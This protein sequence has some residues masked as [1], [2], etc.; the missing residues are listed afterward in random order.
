MRLEPGPAEKYFGITAAPMAALADWH[1]RITNPSLSLRGDIKNACNYLKSLIDNFDFDKAGIAPYKTPDWAQ[2]LLNTGNSAA[3]IKLLEQVHPAKGKPSSKITFTQIRSVYESLEI[4]SEIIAFCENYIAAVVTRT[5][6]TDEPYAGYTDECE[7]LKAISFTKNDSVKY[8][9]V[10]AWGKF[11]PIREVT[12]LRTRAES[13]TKDCRNPN[14]L[15]CR[16]LSTVALFANRFEGAVDA[17]SY[18]DRAALLEMLPFLAEALKKEGRNNSACKN[19]S[20]SIAALIKATGA[21][22]ALDAFIANLE[23]PKPDSDFLKNMTTKY[24]ERAVGELKALTGEDFGDDATKWRAWFEKNRNMLVYIADKKAFTVDA[25]AAAAY[26]A[27]LEK[28]KKKK[29]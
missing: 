15:Y 21:P 16:C 22:E 2:P 23:G 10:E 25:K 6:K 24:T 1:G 8:A 28:A 3:A 5:P 9:A 26:R 12:F 11:A 19:A 13:R 17:E 20:D 29:R 18:E 14:V 7:L 27:E 4:E